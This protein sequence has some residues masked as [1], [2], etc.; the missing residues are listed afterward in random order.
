MVT[1]RVSE[2]ASKKPRPLAVLPRSHFLILRKFSCGTLALLCLL[3]TSNGC[4]RSQDINKI[5]GT[6][7]IFQ[8]DG[9]LQ[10]TADEAAKS[11]RKRIDPT[12][13][14]G[15]QVSIREPKIEIS[16][17]GQTFTEAQV[18][19]LQRVLATASS[20][21]VLR[22]AEQTDVEIAAAI[23]TS[24]PNSQDLVVDGKVIATWRPI[25]IDATGAPRVTNTQSTFVRPGK[26]QGSEILLSI[27]ENDIG[28]E[29][30][31]AANKAFD[32]T[33]RPAISLKFN[34]TGGARMESLSTS[35]KGRMLGVVIGGEAVAT[36]EVMS[37]ISD[38]CM[39]S[40]NYTDAEATFLVT[41]IRVGSLPFRVVDET[42]EV[43][44]VPKGN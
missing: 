22:V 30:V 4:F 17:P 41:A 11:L 13:V 27:S 38:R 21:E 34:E 40:G 8:L 3:A 1:R 26:N 2:D 35:N 43:V 42:P 9:K 14:H 28:A 25:S 7:L 33:D 6:Q 18:Q 20:L 31:E 37:A 24:D 19:M 23:A 16:F 36:P 44:V 39:V 29:H 32:E 15:T 10:V 5:G 12:G